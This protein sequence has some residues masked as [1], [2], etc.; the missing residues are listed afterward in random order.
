MTMGTDT[1][2][3]AVDVRP[4]FVVFGA[5]MLLT[6]VTVAVSYLD[7]PTGPSVSLALAIACGKAALVALFFM[8]LSHERAAIYWP[9]GFTAVFFV[10]LMAFVLWTEADHLYGTR[11]TGAFDGG[12]P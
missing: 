7:L 2:G 5:L 6:V 10:A 12:A 8:H 9:L 3:S 1:R 4:Y 11:F